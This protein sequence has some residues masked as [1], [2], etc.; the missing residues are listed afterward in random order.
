M[1]FFS[2]SSTAYQEAV[3][4]KNTQQY[5]KAINRLKELISYESHK[6]VYY[7]DLGFCLMK[8]GC[9][10]EALNNCS[11]AVELDIKQIRNYENMAVEV[12]SLETG[13]FFLSSWKNVNNLNRINEYEKEIKKCC[14]DRNYIKS[15][16]YLD[17]CLE[18]FPKCVRYKFMK[19]EILVYLEEYEKS[20]I[21]LEKIEDNSIKSI[22][23]NGLLY[24]YDKCDLQEAINCF[25]RVLSKTLSC[26][27]IYKKTQQY[28][29]IT[30]SL[31]FCKEEGNSCFRDGQ[32]SEA[33]DF[34]T[35]GLQIDPHLKKSMQ[36][37]ISIE[38]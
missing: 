2:S 13:I 37:F 20:S 35:K 33:R 14:N 24:L 12:N 18:E 28:Y 38:L 30:K 7:A 11:R 8:L 27:E 23:I 15:L 5:W 1:F 26:D 25:E 22:Y 32:Y 10:Q 29:D 31:K 4:F 6:S 16:Y 17:K 3:N 34:Y 19:A 36:L 9:H 21:I